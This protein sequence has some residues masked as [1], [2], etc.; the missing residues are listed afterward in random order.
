VVFLDT[1]QDSS[2]GIL[3]RYEQAGAHRE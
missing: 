3:E 1:V 2:T